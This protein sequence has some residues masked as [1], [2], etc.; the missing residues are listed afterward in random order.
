M[1]TA[2][3]GSFKFVAFMHYVVAYMYTYNPVKLIWMRPKFTHK[4]L[5]INFGTCMYIVLLHN[6]FLGNKQ[7]NI[8]LKQIKSTL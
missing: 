8:H 5:Q 1:L 3:L 4:M 2:G 7:W 6:I